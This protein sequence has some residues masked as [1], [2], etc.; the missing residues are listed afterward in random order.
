[1]YFETTKIMNSKGDELRELS[2]WILPLWMHIYLIYGNV[3]G[4]C[5]G[6]RGNIVWNLYDLMIDNWGR[7]ISDFGF[8]IYMKLRVV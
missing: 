7:E 6:M 3:Q 2:L 5:T 8:G 1:M 4:Q